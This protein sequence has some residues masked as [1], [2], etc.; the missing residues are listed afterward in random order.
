M[1]AIVRNINRVNR[2]GTSKSGN[3]YHIDQTNV[4]IDVPFDN[5]DGFGSKE[6]SYQYGTSANFAKLEVLRGKL[7]CQVDIELGT[8]LNQYDQPVTVVT[9]VKLQSAQAAK[10]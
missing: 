6:M 7:P 10:S 2:S 3:P 9:D 4:V 1:K 8:E 5:E